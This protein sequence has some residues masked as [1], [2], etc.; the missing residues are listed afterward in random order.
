[1]S[2]RRTRPPPRFG[3]TGSLPDI[4]EACVRNR[5]NAN[6]GTLAATNFLVILSYEPEK[7]SKSVLRSTVEHLSRWPSPIGPKAAQPAGLQSQ[8]KHVRRIEKQ[9]APPEPRLHV[10]PERP[11]Q[12]GLLQPGRGLADGS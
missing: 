12:A 7:Y 6:R 9:I 2:G 5:A 3:R 1:M 4:H 11:L 10:P 8:Q